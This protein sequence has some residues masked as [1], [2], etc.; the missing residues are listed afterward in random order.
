[1][2]FNESILFEMPPLT[3][4]IIVHHRYKEWIESMMAMFGPR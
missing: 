1:M 4:K 2:T 3:K